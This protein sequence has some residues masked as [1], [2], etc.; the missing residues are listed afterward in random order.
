MS[1][2][3]RAALERDGDLKWRAPNVMQVRDG[4]AEAIRVN[5]LEIHNLADRTL[6][7]FFVR[8]AHSFLVQHGDESR[9]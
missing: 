8:E 4:L 9:L 3:N 1:N 6:L 7:T 5:G 2:I